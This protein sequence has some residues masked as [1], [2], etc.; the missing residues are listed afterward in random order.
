M[1]K[2][3][4]GGRFRKKTDSRVEE[5]SSSLVCDKRLFRQ[6]IRA[7]IAHAEALRR[8]GCL[9]GAERKRIVRSLREIENEIG[10]GKITLSGHEDIHSL[11]IDRLIR[12]VGPLGKK[13]HAGRS[14]NDLVLCDLRLYLKEKL[15]EI[16]SAVRGL[17]AA[18]VDKA[19]AEG[20]LIMPGYTHLQHAQPVL[21]AH[22][23]LAYVEMLERDRGRL[24]DAKT[25][26][27]VLPLGSAALAGTS[28][29]LDQ[30][31]L[32]R[33]LGF[34]AV[35]ANS[36][37][38]VSDRD[39]AAEVLSGLAILGMHL[40][41]LAEEIVLWSASEF[42]FVRLDESFCTG[43]SF[44]PQKMN[45]DPAEL[46]RGKTGRLYGNLMALLTVLKGLPLSYN[47]DLQEDKE[48]LF[49][50]LDTVLAELTVMA[51][52]VATLAV[53]REALK[54]AVEKDFSFAADLAEFLVKKGIPF[55]EAHRLVGEL[56]ARCLG[57]GVLPSGVT[58]RDL[59]AISPAF[60]ASA[61]QLFRAE[62]SVRAKATRGSTSPAMVEQALR[63]W[64]KKIKEDK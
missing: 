59:R 49:D 51:P 7:G 35:A 40:S 54:R 42:G 5:F 13:I 47:R 38:A 11:I 46:I 18:L 24:A 48:P 22:H 9:T 57:R 15:E 31:L 30:D 56:V 55:G 52:L 23:L 21:F 53:D 60:D 41:R 19:A 27:D 29:K 39:F 62:S 12:K 10:N 14:R 50:S 25:R 37:D 28:L 3:L 6:D 61:L 26:L 17:Q 44:L 58:L 2:K 34:S 63:R 33:L 4:W 36:L 20:E 16:A 64:K 43:S 1:K 32:A 8:A 45:P